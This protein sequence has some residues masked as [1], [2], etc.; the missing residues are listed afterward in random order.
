MLQ[1][2]RP[3]DLQADRADEQAA[4]SD[5]P[6]V[7]IGRFIVQPVIDEPRLLVVA[8]GTI[9]HENRLDVAQVG[10]RLVRG[11]GSGA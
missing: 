6:A 4:G 10:R 7:G 1:D 11:P 2:R 9:A 5:F 3:D 8:A